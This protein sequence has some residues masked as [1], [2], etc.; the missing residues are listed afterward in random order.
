MEGFFSA[1]GPHPSNPLLKQRG[2]TRI[3][4]MTP[5]RRHLI[6]IPPIHPQI[7]H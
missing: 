6:S 4:D 2:A 5:N 1:S 3:N 7:K